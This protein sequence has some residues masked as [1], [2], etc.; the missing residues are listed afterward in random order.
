MSAAISAG[1]SLHIQPQ[2]HGTT[3]KRLGKYIRKAK[4]QDKNQDHLS[5]ED[6]QAS[7]EKLTYWS[8]SS[9]LIDKIHLEGSLDY[10]IGKPNR[11]RFRRLGGGELLASDIEQQQKSL[12]NTTC[13]HQYHPSYTQSWLTN[14]ICR[15]LVHH[16]LV[17]YLLSV[18]IGAYMLMQMEESNN[19]GVV[20]FPDNFMDQ[21]LWEECR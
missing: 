18:N 19:S 8:R 1:R 6:S 14:F 9:A 5:K 7:K 21:L 10:C 13:L 16:I 4:V 12:S 20:D 11:Q 15:S 3:R 2:A 17:I